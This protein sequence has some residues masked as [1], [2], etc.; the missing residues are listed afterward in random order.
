MPLVTYVPQEN[1]DPIHTTCCGLKFSASEPVEVPNDAMVLQLIVEKKLHEPSGDI[2]S[3]AVEKNV[4][5]I[6]ILKKNPY[7]RVEGAPE[8]PKKQAGRPRTP[9]TADEYK[10]FAMAW[11]AR[12]EN[13]TALAQRWE[14]EA[15]LREKLGVH[16]DGE[17]V[18]YLR[19]FFDARHFEL[20][21]AA[22]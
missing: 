21:K 18:S 20:R 16:D 1:G 15:S 12:T 13:H 14:A 17:I 7:F 9:Q 4:P 5:I 10:G 2:R 8:P 22:A 6:E 3:K 19:P 11:F